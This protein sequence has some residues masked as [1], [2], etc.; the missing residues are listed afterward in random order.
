MPVVESAAVH[1][2]PRRTITE[3]RRVAPL[4]LPNVF[5]VG[6]IKSGTT[7]LYHYFKQHPQIF[8]P[9][10]IKET[11]FMA[12][13]EGMPPLSGPGDQAAW[14]GNSITTLTDYQNLYAL[15]TE[16]PLAADVSPSYLYYPQAAQ[17]LPSCART[18]KL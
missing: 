4:D 1:R 12:F 7:A 14:T 11:N 9:Q 2:L 6:A 3:R 16:Q 13:C 15:R 10:S 17:K 18:P 5:V 8:V